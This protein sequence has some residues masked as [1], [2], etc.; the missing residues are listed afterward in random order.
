MNFIEQIGGFLVRIL[1]RALVASMLVLASPFA[2][3]GD[4]RLVVPAP[5]GGAMDS[6][7]RL[8]ALHL[9][10]RLGEPVLVENRPGA[11]T[12]IG[13]EYVVRSA[14]DGRTLLFGAASTAINPAL[15]KLRFDV[16]RDLAPVV[17]VSVENYVLVV[18]DDLPVARL[19]DLAG[20]A[21]GKPGGLNCAAPPGMMMLACEQ[22][23]INLGGDMT[24]IPYPGVAPALTAL[25]GGTVDLAFLP[26]QSVSGQT[27]QGRL[28]ALANAGTQKADVPYP[29]LPLLSEAWPGFAVSGMYGVLVPAG[30]PAE[31]IKSLNEKINAVLQIATVREQILRAW[32]VPVGGTPEQYA[33]TM[34]THHGYYQRLIRQAG[35]AVR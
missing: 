2:Q 11:A 30:T 27:T 1:S 25:L 18:R 31:T 35:I 7:A 33:Q 32:Q 24:A 16:F 6:T 29:E 26:L 4:I 17:Q 13:T 20:H 9:A 10:E 5:P 8:I 23:R 19:S 14:P 21:K 12:N 28:R 3:A 15:Y 22:L 34:R